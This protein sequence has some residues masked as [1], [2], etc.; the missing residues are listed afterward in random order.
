MQK[1]NSFY[2]NYELIDCGDF[3]KLE[4]FSGV[5]IQRPAPQADFSKVLPDNVWDS[6]SA[7]F[8]GKEWIIND[9]KI[10]NG[11]TSKIDTATI[12]LK[13][14]TGG[15][16]GVFP[17]QAINWSW[18]KEAVNRGGK[19][20]NIFNGFGYTGLSTIFASSSTSNVCHVDASKSAVTWAKKNSQLSGVTPNNIRWIVDD[21]V[22]FLKRDV[23]RG[24]KYDG[25][26]LDPP[27]F[28]RG[29][30]GKTW[31][32]KRDIDALL[33]ISS[34]LLSDNPAFFVLT[35]HDHEMTAKE[36]GVLLGKVDKTFRGKMEVFEMLIQATSGN[37]LKSGLCARV[38]LF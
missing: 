33:Y 31:S 18:L 23:K 12:E 28:G 32:L 2:K 10:L 4:S 38:K 3:K 7:I 6:A 8:D 37:V 29:K 36:L 30:D 22:T 16:V 27:A 1:S 25:F 9:Q 5:V 21:V 17:E 13:T 34:T 20:L 19:T 24:V 35:C 15:Q 11:W 26:I 14:S